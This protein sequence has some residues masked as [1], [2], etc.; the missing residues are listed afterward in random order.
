MQ[1]AR[2]WLQRLYLGACASSGLLFVCTLVQPQWIE[3][4][5]DASPDGGDG[6]AERLVVGGCCL[7][8]T[9]LAGCMAR[10]EQR[11]GAL[12]HAR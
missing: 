10:H 5:L 3:R 11:R 2:P 1:I 12:L 9:V 8:L 7:L 6:S 4:W